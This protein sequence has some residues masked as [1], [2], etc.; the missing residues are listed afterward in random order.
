[1]NRSDIEKTNEYLTR[2]MPDVLSD[3]LVKMVL[4]GSC[5]RGDYTEDSDIDIV[6]LTKCDRMTAKKYDGRLMDVVTDIAFNF[7]TI[8]QYTCIPFSEYE[9][10]KSWYGY[11]KNIDKDGVVLYG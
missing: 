9:E 5:A 8:V 3:D 1:M 6:L 2:F 11:F 4:Y 7:G 10:K